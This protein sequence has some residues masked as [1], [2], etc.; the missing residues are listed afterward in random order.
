M[1]PVI[2]QERGWSK[3]N[4]NESIKKVIYDIA[5]ERLNILVANY[6]NSGECLG[7]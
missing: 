7:G 1:W 5:F 4:D 3:A 2:A 6:E